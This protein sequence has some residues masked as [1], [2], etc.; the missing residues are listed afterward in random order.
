MLSLQNIL[1]KKCCSL[2]L[3]PIFWC[4]YEV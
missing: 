3:S 1:F 2:V 4:D